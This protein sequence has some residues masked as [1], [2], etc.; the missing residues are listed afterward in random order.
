MAYTGV[1]IS[2]SHV[3]QSLVNSY[4]LY[5]AS[6]ISVYFEYFAL[7]NISSI[8]EK[9]RYNW[10]LLSVLYMLN[11]RQLLVVHLEWSYHDR[12]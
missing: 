8:E 1:Y 2:L 7:S 10:T 9:Q 3:L 4:R 12:K 6:N 5:R 11:N